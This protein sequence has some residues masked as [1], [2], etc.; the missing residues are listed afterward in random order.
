MSVC[1]APVSDQTASTVPT[2]AI[3]IPELALFSMTRVR[4]SSTRVSASRGTMPASFS[5]IV[6]I[7]S[8]LANKLN[9]PTATSS[10]DGI[11]RNE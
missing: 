5:V 3:A 4:L 1:I 8:G 11:A 6:P 9:T 2:S 7:A 10:K